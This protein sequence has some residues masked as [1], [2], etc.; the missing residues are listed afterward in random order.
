[1]LSYT[2]IILLS[3]LVNVDLPETGIID[4]IYIVE[5]PTVAGRVRT[6]QNKLAA[7]AVLPAEA[8]KTRCIIHHEEYILMT[9]K[10]QHL[11][12]HDIEVM[13]RILP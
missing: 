5:V 1:M 4:H 8:R 11:L 2:E 6:T 13:F 3:S 10:R 9:E 12:L 7:A